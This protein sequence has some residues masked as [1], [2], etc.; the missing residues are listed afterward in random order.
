MRASPGPGGRDTCGNVSVTG[1]G[2]SHRGD[3]RCWCARVGCSV[4]LPEVP[5]EVV[6]RRPGESTARPVCRYPGVW[7]VVQR[8]WRDSN[9]LPDRSV[10]GHVAHPA[11][12]HLPG[13]ASV[14]PSPPGS[15]PEWSMRD[16][17]T[18]ARVANSGL[19]SGEEDRLP[20]PGT[21]HVCGVGSGGGVGDDKE[22]AQPLL[23]PKPREHRPPVARV[24]TGPGRGAEVLD[25]RPPLE[26]LQGV[27]GTVAAD[28][29]F[30]STP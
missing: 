20:A 27:A 26:V 1:W 9:R 18:C 28:G 16:P 4:P 21:E 15:W 10:R 19:R 17:R 7:R 30:R 3:W 23:T 22:P 25:G 6:R 5:G 14:P 13:K 11:G 24:R 2:A 29:G 12:T 8:V